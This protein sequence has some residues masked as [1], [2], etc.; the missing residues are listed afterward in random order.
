[1]EGSG[2]DIVEVLSRIYMDR[3]RKNM[4][5]VS[6]H[7]LSRPSTFQIQVMTVTAAPSCSLQIYLSHVVFD[8]TMATSSGTV[9][10]AAL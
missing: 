9:V 5:N 2:R 7:A 4:K 6:G 8:L 1:L 10:A 3:L